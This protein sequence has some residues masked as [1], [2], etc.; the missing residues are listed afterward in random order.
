LALATARL[1]GPS[2][3]ATGGLFQNSDV[4]I[5]VYSEPVEPD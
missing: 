2:R 5:V 3:G 1:L 4:Q